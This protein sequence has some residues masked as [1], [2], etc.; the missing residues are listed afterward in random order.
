M[1]IHQVEVFGT[2]VD[3]QTRCSHYHSAVD[4]IAIKFKCCGQWFPC[5][6]CHAE[7]TNHPSQVWSKAENNTTAVLCGGCGHQLS[8][9]EYLKCASVC[10]KCNS[11]FNP[12]CALHYHLYFES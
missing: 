5:F 12:Q 10:P 9:E 4:I 3:G 2:Q 1:L 7:Y 6:K 11:A 8:I